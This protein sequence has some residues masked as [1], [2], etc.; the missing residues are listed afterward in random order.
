MREYLSTDEWPTLCETPP[1]P[2]FCGSLTNGST[3]ACF[4]VQALF[5]GEGQAC[6][7]CL[8][9]DFIHEIINVFAIAGE[10]REM[11]AA[12]IIEAVSMLFLMTKK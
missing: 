9:L 12:S 3:G 11:L 2:I 4:C 1:L 8:L 5:G 10:D 7:F 6:I